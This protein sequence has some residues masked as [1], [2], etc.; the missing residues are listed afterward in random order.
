MQ[1]QRQWQDVINRGDE[2]GIIQFWKTYH[3]RQGFLP[4][5]QS[6]QAAMKVLKSAEHRRYA[7]EIARISDLQDKTTRLVPGSSAI[8]STNPDPEDDDDINFEDF[9][10]DDPSDIIDV[11]SNATVP[12]S[13]EKKKLNPVAVQET[14]AKL[15]E[16][17][18]AQAAVP[19]EDKKRKAV[20]YAKEEQEAD[21]KKLRILLDPEDTTQCR[22]KTRVTSS[23]EASCN[24]FTNEVGEQY[25]Y[26]DE[27][28][29]E[30]IPRDAIV[31]IQG[32]C[33]DRETVRRTARNQY[34]AHGTL[35]R[36][37]D[38]QPRG[39]SGEKVSLD[40]FKVWG[41][42]YSVSDAE[43]QANRQAYYNNN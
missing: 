23:E 16:T 2:S 36:K 17:M 13:W 22:Y 6:M 12:L 26:M 9:G 21:E 31:N 42:D 20:E 10:D 4:T 18:L 1:L 11:S 14:Q 24:Q 35:F 8:F 3:P 29:S 34:L 7:H 19:E 30:C 32:N 40:D 28:T 33:Y 15:K 37:G 25:G 41:I 39:P 38:V 27:I 5:Q 43:M